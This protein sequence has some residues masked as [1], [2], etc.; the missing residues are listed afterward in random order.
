M[1]NA[2]VSWR[3]LAALF[4]W[5]W[6]GLSF[7]YLSFS[8]FLCSCFST[9]VL[10]CYRRNH[11]K[12]LYLRFTWHWAKDGGKVPAPEN[13]Y[14][15]YIMLLFKNQGTRLHTHPQTKCRT[16]LDTHLSS[17]VRNKI[18]QTKET[19]EYYIC[20]MVKVYTFSAFYLSHFELVP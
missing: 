8:L 9:F 5:F 14:R 2:H 10:H 16:W 6:L 13:C 12:T 11:S 17:V 19:N 3:G 7:P 18:K 20:N 1:R 15:F 4:H